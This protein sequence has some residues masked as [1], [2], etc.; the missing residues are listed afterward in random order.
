MAHQEKR[1]RWWRGPHWSEGFPANSEDPHQPALSVPKYPESLKN[2][3]DF[4]ERELAQ[5]GIH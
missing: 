2:I 1:P 4:I 3:P 5:T